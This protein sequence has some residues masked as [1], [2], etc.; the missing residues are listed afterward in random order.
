MVGSSG[1]QPNDSSGA[2]WS[3][4]SELG[5]FYAIKVG[6]ARHRAVA[7]WKAYEASGRG[8]QQGAELQQ[9]LIAEKEAIISWKTEERR[10][11]AS[12]TEIE[13]A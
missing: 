1:G 10:F 8:V 9:A 5:E 13:C 7:A 4:K 11:K 2:K 6:R 3:S 12:A